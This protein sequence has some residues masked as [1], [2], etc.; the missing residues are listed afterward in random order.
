MM[1][2]YTFRCV[3]DA[4]IKKVLLPGKRFGNIFFDFSIF[5]IVTGLYD[6]QYLHYNSDIE[7]ISLYFSFFKTV[8][9]RIVLMSL[10]FLL[11]ISYEGG[12]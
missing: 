6:L 10:V 8:F 1:I 4:K 7:N 11:Y 9:F 3:T 5:S 12:L 2:N